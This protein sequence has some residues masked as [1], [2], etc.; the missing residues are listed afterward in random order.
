MFTNVAS[1]LGHHPVLFGMII[2]R[3]TACSLR[4]Q[5]EHGTARCQ[6]K[7]WDHCSLSWLEN[8][9]LVLGTQEIVI[10]IMI[11]HHSKPFQ[12][13]FF[14]QRS[15]QNL[16]ATAPV[17]SCQLPIPGRSAR[18]NWSRTPKR[19]SCSEGAT[20]WG[21][22]GCWGAGVLDAKIEAVDVP[23]IEAWKHQLHYE[24][25]GGFPKITWRFIIFFEFWD[26]TNILYRRRMVSRVA[27]ILFFIPWYQEMI[28]AR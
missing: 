14:S 12:P 24:W 3:A 21:C 1:E 20:C 10:S 27:N 17:A 2:D 28:C 4:P 6:R 22:W 25:L 9:D 7:L 13:I 23:K 26:P 18:R 15:I 11:F 16:E 8:H 19:R 5:F